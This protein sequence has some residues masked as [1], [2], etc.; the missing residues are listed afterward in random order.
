MLPKLNKMSK[1]FKAAS[2]LLVIKKC[3]NKKRK[4]MASSKWNLRCLNKSNQKNI[5]HQC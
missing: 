1:R 4:K 3:R 5:T 2:R